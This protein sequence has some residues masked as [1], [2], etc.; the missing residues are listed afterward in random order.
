MDLTYRQRSV[1]DDVKKW[2][3]VWP[4]DGYTRDQG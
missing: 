4:E 1:K 3:L 2:P